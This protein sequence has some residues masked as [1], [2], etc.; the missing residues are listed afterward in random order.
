MSAMPLTAARKRT[1]PDVRKVPIVLQK[2]PSRLCEMEICNNRIG[3]SV[4]LKS[5]LLVRA[6]SLVNVSRPNV[7]NTFAT[8]S[9][10]SGLM[11]C[12]KKH[13]S[14]ISSARPD[15]GRGMV[16]PSARAVFKLMYISTLV[17]CCTGRSAGFS[18]LRIRPVYMPA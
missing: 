4:L 12:N 5:L 15:S 16:M 6:R 17:A 9:A 14:K 10:I 3:A 11:H 13:H 7:K 1:S 2:S 18:P 8:Q